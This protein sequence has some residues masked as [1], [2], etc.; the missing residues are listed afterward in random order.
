MSVDRYAVKG[1]DQRRSE[2]HHLTRTIADLCLAS[3]S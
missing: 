2:M 3:D 1:A